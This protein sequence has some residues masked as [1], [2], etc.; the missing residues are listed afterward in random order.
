MLAVNVAPNSENQDQNIVTVF[1]L[2]ISWRDVSFPV[3]F[4]GVPLGEYEGIVSQGWKRGYC[5][6]IL[7]Y[8]L[9]ARKVEISVEFY[10][11]F[12]FFNYLRMIIWLGVLLTWGKLYFFYTREETETLNGV[13]LKCT[14]MIRAVNKLYRGSSCYE[15]NTVLIDNSCLL[16][17]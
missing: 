14:R 6:F 8:K 4:F 10:T 2:Q 15:C 3:I 1:D 9:R 12:F 13:L 11:F 16:S 5:K 7:K 17:R